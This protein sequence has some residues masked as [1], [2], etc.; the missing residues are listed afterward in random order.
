M[1]SVISV[2]GVA[3]MYLFGAILLIGGGIP[4]IWP[5]LMGQKGGK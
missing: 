5:H 2:V 3:L 4:V 1:E